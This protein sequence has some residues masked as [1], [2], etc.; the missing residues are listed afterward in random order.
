MQ[1]KKWNDYLKA[2][3]ILI[4]IIDF[5]NIENLFNFLIIKIEL[6]LSVIKVIQPPPSFPLPPPARRVYKVMNEAEPGI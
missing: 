3:T 4:L 2:E 6:S 5:K 1:G